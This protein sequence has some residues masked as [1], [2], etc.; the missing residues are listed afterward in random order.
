MTSN[1]DD[2]KIEERI[3]FYANILNLSVGT[4]RS[5]FKD[6]KSRQEYRDNSGRWTPSYYYKVYNIKD[7]LEYLRDKK[8]KHYSKIKEYYDKEHSDFK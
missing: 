8:P 2:F 6:I 3:E 4:T 5:Y 1:K 7:V